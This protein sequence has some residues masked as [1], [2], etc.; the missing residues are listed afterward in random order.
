[1]KETGI[2]MLI[3]KMG[4]PMY[5]LE[6]RKMGISITAYHREALLEEISYGPC[7]LAL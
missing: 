5:L 3:D 2:Y 6:S 4:K 1:M 7:V